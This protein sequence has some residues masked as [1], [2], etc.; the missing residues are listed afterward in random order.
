MSETFRCDD[1]ETLVAYLYGEIDDDG[2]R[3][4]ERHLRSCAACA[5]ETEGLQAVRRDLES[6]MPPDAELGFTIV[7]KPATVLRPSRWASVRAMP[8]WAQVAAAALVIGVGVAIAN[9]QVRYAADSLTVSTG[10][11][12]PDNL[13]TPTPTQAPELPRPADD[14][15]PALVALE[16][17]LRSEMADMKRTGAP[18]TLRAAATASNDNAAILRRV[19]TMLED[20]EE[21]QRQEVAARMLL[22]NRDFE[23]RRRADLFNISQNLG[24]LNRQTFKTAAEQQELANLVRRVRSQPIP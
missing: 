2:R 24:S 1:K 9:V 8:A 22:M 3:E 21:R 17:E 7:P 16:Q 20:S 11:M 23:A 18:E 15:K 14:W 19:Q 13:A 10:W 5:M 6:W 12:T 4:V